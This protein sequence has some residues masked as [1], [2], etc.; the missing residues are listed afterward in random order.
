[1][2]GSTRDSSASIGRTHN[3]NGL[4]VMNARCRPSGESA[5]ICAGV[6]PG[7]ETSNRSASRAGGARRAY[8]NDSPTT[9]ASRSADTAGQSHDV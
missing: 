4:P 9:A 3:C 8:R 1:M 6:L 7:V 5:N 2:S